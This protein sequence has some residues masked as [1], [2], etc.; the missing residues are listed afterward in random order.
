MCVWVGGCMCWGVCVSYKITLIFVFNDI[1]FL[2]WVVV[3]A[4]AKIA[5]II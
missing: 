5:Q 1:H 2:A 3:A 4:V